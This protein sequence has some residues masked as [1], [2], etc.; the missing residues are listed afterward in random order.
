MSNRKQR[1]MKCA[2]KSR[3]ELGQQ[4]DGI[5]RQLASLGQPQLHQVGRRSQHPVRPP[6]PAAG[7]NRSSCPVMTTRSR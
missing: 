2:L 6:T 7:T 3:R 1:K 4:L 5:P